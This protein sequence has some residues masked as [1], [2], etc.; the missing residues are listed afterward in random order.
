MNHLP[1]TV[2]QL[3]VS[4]ASYLSLSL[5]LTADSKEQNWPDE[6]SL[7][8]VASKMALSQ[9]GNNWLSVDLHTFKLQE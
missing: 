3:M 9:F 2:G 1:L 6:A 8:V 5:P 7:V 4:P